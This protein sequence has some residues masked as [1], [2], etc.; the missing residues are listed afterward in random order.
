MSNDM[1]LKVAGK[2]T[3]EHIAAREKLVNDAV[4]AGKIVPGRANHYRAAYDADPGGTRQVIANLAAVLPSDPNAGVLA[5]LPAYP[6]GWL[7]VPERR[8][9]EAAKVGV[10]P[11]RITTE[12]A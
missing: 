3:A 6:A 4:A 8:S 2:Y 9:V 1:G 7:S 10:R 11:W 5:K 12:A